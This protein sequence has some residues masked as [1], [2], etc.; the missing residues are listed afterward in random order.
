[1]TDN[2]KLTTMEQIVKYMQN[3]NEMVAII[4][5]H[6]RYSQ[7]IKDDSK[8]IA[9]QAFTFTAEQTDPKMIDKLVIDEYRKKLNHQ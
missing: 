1:M 2:K 8:K 5:Q 7:K 9:L 6:T 4:D 3:I